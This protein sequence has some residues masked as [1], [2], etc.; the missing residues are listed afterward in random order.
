[1]IRKI[2]ILR[3]DTTYIFF[4]NISIY[5]D[6]RFSANTLKTTYRERPSKEICFASYG[7]STRYSNMAVNFKLATKEEERKYIEEH[8][9]DFI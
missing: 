9:E 5:P 6:D 7:A 4:R 3:I 1:M 8:P 2:Q